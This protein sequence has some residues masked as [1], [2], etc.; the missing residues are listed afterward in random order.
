MVVVE[1]EFSILHRLGFPFPA[2]ATMQRAGLQ[3]R[4]TSW[5]IR[6]SCTSLSVSFFWPT[7]ASSETPANVTKYSL[8]PKRRRRTR[9]RNKSKK[10]GVAE[11]GPILPP[12]DGSVLDTGP[13]SSPIPVDTH[14]RSCHHSAAVDSPDPV[15]S[16]DAV[17]QN[18]LNQSFPIKSLKPSHDMQDVVIEPEM[19]LAKRTSLSDTISRDSGT[20]HDIYYRELDSSTPGVCVVSDDGKLTWSPVKITRSCVKDAASDHDSESAKDSS[21]DSED[22]KPSQ[23]ATM[24]FE[25]R[26]GV[27]GFEIV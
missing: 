24:G 14:P 20:L 23:I 8:K 13:A 1:G 9:Q 12:R 3:L 7:S 18:T 15:I 6:K 2:L 27:P 19:I 26:S 16:T 22:L 25:N 5:D 11:P 4:D 10:P 17:T 21:S